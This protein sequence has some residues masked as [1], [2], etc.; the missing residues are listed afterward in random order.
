M[1]PIRGDQIK[2][3][4]YLEKCETKH[5]IVSWINVLISYIHWQLSSP[6]FWKNMN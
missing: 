4:L 6:K 3:R 2:Y 1:E 5:K